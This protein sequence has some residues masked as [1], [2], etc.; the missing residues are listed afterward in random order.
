MRLYPVVEKCKKWTVLAF[1]TACNS[2][3]F[4]CASYR[5]SKWTKSWNVVIL[6]SVGAPLALDMSYSDS[7][8]LLRFLIIG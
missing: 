1:Y 4:T 2:E 8:M 6:N 3:K 5:R 7:C